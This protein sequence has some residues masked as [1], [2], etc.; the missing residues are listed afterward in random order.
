M[1][2]TLFYRGLLGLIVIKDLW[3]VYDIYVH[4]CM[5]TTRVPVESPRN[6]VIDGYEPPWWV[7]GGSFVR[8]THTLKD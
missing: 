2:M 1:E 4:M 6:G 3:Y 8:A 7:M 5:C